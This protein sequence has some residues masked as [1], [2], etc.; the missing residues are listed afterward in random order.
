MTN[1]LLFSFRIKP[2]IFSSPN[3]PPSFHVIHPL[4]HFVGPQFPTYT[5]FVFFLDLSVLPN[6]SFVGRT[7]YPT[8]N[9]IRSILLS[10]LFS[11][12]CGP[13]NRRI[14]VRIDG[15]RIRR[16]ERNLNRTP[17]RPPQPHVGGMQTVGFVLQARTKL[18]MGMAEWEGEYNE[19]GEKTAMNNGRTDVVQNYCIDCRVLCLERKTHQY[20]Y[21]YGYCTTLI[22]SLYISIYT[23]VCPLPLSTFFSSSSSESLFSGLRCRRVRG[24]YRHLIWSPV[25]DSL[26]R[27]YLHF[28]LMRR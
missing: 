23:F 9:T 8:T 27:I 1:L 26:I 5:F 17:Y 12:K 11:A 3:F 2:D 13:V 24:T 14:G 7:H 16:L 15:R 10:I 21:S 25:C 20:H 4:L 18:S 28:L 6:A 22:L 19:G